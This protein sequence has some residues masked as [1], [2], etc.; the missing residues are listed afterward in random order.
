MMN[1]ESNGNCKKY[2]KQQKKEM[3]EIKHYSQKY[4]IIK[5]YKYATLLKQLKNYMI[6]SSKA[7]KVRF[8]KN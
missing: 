4:Y 3:M 5:V 1:N 2:N 6:K 8:K 7:L